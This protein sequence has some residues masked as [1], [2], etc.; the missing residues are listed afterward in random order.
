MSTRGLA[1]LL[2]LATWSIAFSAP[3][4][5]ETPSSQNDTANANLLPADLLQISGTDA[6]SK[7]VFLVDKTERH[8]QVFERK[9]E[10]IEKIRIQHFRCR[11]FS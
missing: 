10:T 3:A 4:A 9:G 7:Y 2:A 1:T 5:D 8:L 11:H 6:F